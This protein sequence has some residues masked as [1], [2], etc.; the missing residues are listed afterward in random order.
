MTY[1]DCKE[2]KKKTGRGPTKFMFFDRLDEIVGDQPNHS[3]PH[4]ID[5]VNYAEPND[6]IVDQNEEVENSNKHEEAG[7]PNNRKRKQPTLEYIKMKQQ[8]YEQKELLW[9]QYLEKKTTR[10]DEM[11]QIQRDKVAILKQLVEKQ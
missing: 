7:K 6:Q 5:L 2:K 9:K 8:Y 1:K 3:S 4:T 11:L 10:D